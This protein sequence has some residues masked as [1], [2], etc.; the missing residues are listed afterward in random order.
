MGSITYTMFT[1][2]SHERYTIVTLLLMLFDVQVGC[3]MYYISEYSMS[4]IIA[5]KVLETKRHASLNYIFKPLR[6]VPIQSTNMLTKFRYWYIEYK[7]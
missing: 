6:N 5:M 7:R 2:T 4:F 1:M 3:S